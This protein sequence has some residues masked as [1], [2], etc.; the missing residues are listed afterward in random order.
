MRTL[1][2]TTADPL[3]LAVR[4]AIIDAA[5]QPQ[6]RRQPGDLDI[7]MGGYKHV[8]GDAEDL[9]EVAVRVLRET[10]ADRL[11]DILAP[12]PGTS[13]PLA[14]GAVVKEPSTA[15]I[16]EK[17][18]TVTPKPFLAVEHEPTRPNPVYQQGDSHRHVDTDGLRSIADEAV[19][20]RLAKVKF[21]ETGTTDEDEET[22]TEAEWLRANAASIA[23]D[24]EAPEVPTAEFPA[25]WS[26]PYFTSLDR[27]TH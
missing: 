20:K 26:A 11:R 15:V 4:S 25:H 9:A 13:P 18:T 7:S 17:D 19:A 23:Q 8:Y 21:F 5:R 14:P 12:P 27:C 24:D 6:V 2:P 1:G 16:A 3:V 22:Y 10:L